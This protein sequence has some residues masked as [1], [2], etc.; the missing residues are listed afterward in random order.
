MRNLGLEQNKEAPEPARS[1]A[2]GGPAFGA[3]SQQPAAAPTAARK[4]GFVLGR[5]LIFKGELYAEED[6]TLQGRV[7]GSIK[8]TQSITVGADG[9]VLGDINARAITIDGTVEGDLHGVESVVVHASGRVN[10]NIFAP[11]VGLVEGAYFS[12]RIDMGPPPGGARRSTSSTSATPGA[13]ISS[14]DTDRIL[15]GS[16][17]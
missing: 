15:G 5:T 12:G 1:P 3:T 7:E 6:L 14:E 4:P 8:H 9:S 13:S 17:A 16:G 2:F 11:R 10:G